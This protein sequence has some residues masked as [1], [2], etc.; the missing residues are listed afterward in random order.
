M[1]QKIRFPFL[2]LG[3][4]VVAIASC[5]S[6]KGPGK[7]GSKDDIVVNNYGMPQAESSDLPVPESGPQP[8]EASLPAE[9]SSPATE[10]QDNSVLNQE[11]PEVPEQ[12]TVIQEQQQEPAAA[13]PADEFTAQP[14]PGSLEPVPN[15]VA[16][17]P[18]VAGE[19]AVVQSGPAPSYDSASTPDTAYSLAPAAATAAASAPLVKPDDKQQASMQGGV[20]NQEQAGYSEESQ[21]LPQAAGTPSKEVFS[22]NDAVYIRSAQEV[23]KSQGQYDGAADGTVNAGFLNALTVYQAKNGLPLGGLNEDTLRHMGVIE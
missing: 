20:G 10:P 4:A 9:S 17:P 12:E 22:Y 16:A 3:V 11:I 14:V 8:V 23:L 15:A 5:A 7:I 19:D 21:A 6:E 13:V 1:S 18:E 2:L